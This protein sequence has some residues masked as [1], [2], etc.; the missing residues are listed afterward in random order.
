MPQKSACIQCHTKKR[1]CGGQI[2]V[3][4]RCRRLSLD[5]H[6]PE[7]RRKTGPKR[8]HLGPLFTKLAEI[9]ETI[10]IDSTYR[11]SSSIEQNDE[12]SAGSR[13]IMSVL[14]QNSLQ[15]TNS[16]DLELGWMGSFLPV[17][18][19]LPQ[20]SLSELCHI[21]FRDIHPTL[22]ILH[23]SKY[24]HKKNLHKSDDGIRCLRYIVWSHAASVCES[25]SHMRDRFY[26]QARGYACANEM[27]D[28]VG[29]SLIQC[30]ALVLI[31]YYEYKHAIF[32][33][34]WLTAGKAMRLALVLKLHRMDSGVHW[35]STLDV[36]DEWVE[37]EERRRT[38]WSAFCVD[39]Y[40]GFGGGFLSMTD[41]SDISTYL[42]SEDEAFENDTIPKNVSHTLATA[43]QLETSRSLSSFGS[44]VV[45]SWLAAR[46]ANHLRTQDDQK[47]WENHHVIDAQLLQ[48]SLS[49]P[50]HLKLPGG[51][52]QPN[53]VLTNMLLHALTVS[54]HQAAVS[55]ATEDPVKKHLAWESNMRCLTSASEIANIVKEVTQSN[56]AA[57]HVLT[58]F[59]IF[60][61]LRYLM[62]QPQRDAPESKQ[63]CQFLTDVL[64]SCVAKQNNLLAG[65][66]LHARI[67]QLEGQP[68]NQSVRRYLPAPKHNKNSSGCLI[69]TGGVCHSFQKS[70]G[71]G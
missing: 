17:E 35:N 36:S 41:E 49:L 54:L 61:A 6:Y 46:T 40:S 1:R 8:A 32:P 64:G 14:D 48:I 65:L 11:P 29:I 70:R 56:L 2:P 53:V 24:F 9:E 50:S 42:P 25:L 10:N 66:F 44:A 5:C 18:T 58:P 7:S 52:H 27:N 59:C 60:V 39:S 21:F 67:L 69:L 30:Q 55:K 26:E 13:E 3:C 20:E 15:P 51:I 19:E 28:N 22:P 34:A 23:P 47:Y 38:F 31:S 43:L 37:L 45:L 33:R 68:V 62:T 63:T 71:S 57:I 4:D 12:S 16:L